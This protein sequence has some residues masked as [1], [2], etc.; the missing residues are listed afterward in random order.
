MD[1]AA[2]VTAEG[3]A[4]APASP[5]TQI[6]E[7]EK[8]R[9][10]DE[11]RRLYELLL[12]EPGDHSDLAAGYGRVLYKSRDF[13]AALKPLSD[14]V[15]ANPADQKS[16]K[17]LATIVRMR[18]LGPAAEQHV[19]EP[20]AGAPRA[21]EMAPDPKETADPL[22]VMLDLARRVD[23]ERMSGRLARSGHGFSD[24]AFPQIDYA[25]HPGYGAASDLI[26]DRSDD[27]IGPL[28]EAFAPIWNG[29]V[30]MKARVSDLPVPPTRAREF[31]VLERDGIVTLRMTDA[32]RAEMMRL[33]EETAQAV[34]ARR[35]T[36]SP[37]KRGVE[38]SSGS[39]YHMK[40]N[41]TEFVEFLT[42]IFDDHG[43]L[44]MASAYQGVPMHI[45][46]ANLQI[47]SAE[48]T[49]ISG[50][51]TVGDL[52]LS[53]GYYLHIDSSLGVMKVII[54]RSA[55]S[56]EMGAFR[57]IPGSN[58]IGVTPFELCLRKA[59]D[60][61]NYDS[62]TVNNRRLFAQLPA[63]LQKK[64]NFGND[65]LAGDPELERLLA[66]ETVMAGEGGDMLLF[67][68]NGIHR[69]AIFEFGEREIIQVLLAP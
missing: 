4:P 65:L 35:A 44:A 23:N 8:A 19:A 34:R 66:L 28:Y 62:C 68:N 45:K 46:L 36:R 64:A 55:V 14:A 38:S 49:S 33:T 61:S 31:D 27:V 40:Q 42:R 60:K 32:E 24:L 25:N 10:W 52:P 57:Y 63:V 59:T 6:R 67:D 54:Y 9:R 58:R 7:L 15:L 16:A 50:D 51:C 26:G 30:S 53:P 43:I 2:T 17:R 37:R 1:D 20:K 41:R 18:A 21:E 11:A 29:Y 39:L 13:D 48:D 56:A 3:R 5:M 69:G 47:N 12:A 22:K